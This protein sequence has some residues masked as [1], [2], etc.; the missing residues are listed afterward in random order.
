MK[1]IG[2]FTIPKLV[3]L[4]ANCSHSS[5]Y[6]AYMVR[7]TIRNLSFPVFKQESTKA[8]KQAKRTSHNV[9]RLLLLFPINVKGSILTEIE[10]NK[11]FMLLSPSFSFF[12][13]LSLF[14]G[15]YE[16]FGLSFATKCHSLLSIESPS[17]RVSEKYV[18]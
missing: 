8:S 11:F 3:K 18:Q 17:D 16:L 9:N 14:I 2:L 13:F 4:Q 5:I 1:R 10:C 12:L 7:L 15:Q 6:N